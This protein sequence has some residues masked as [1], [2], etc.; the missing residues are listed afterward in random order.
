MIMKYEKTKQRHQKLKVVVLT[1]YGNGKLACMR[2]GFG[3]VHA[4]SIDHISGG[5]NNE[6][7]K[8]RGSGQLY[9]FLKGNNFPRGYQTLCMNCQFIK[10]F[11]N[12]EDYWHEK[13]AKEKAEGLLVEARKPLYLSKVTPANIWKYI[14]KLTVIQFE[15]DQIKKAF[16]VEDNDKEEQRI[17]SFLSRSVQS[18]KLQHVAHGVYERV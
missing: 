5:G 1:H 10:R 8:M 15:V 13:R 2:C 4:L 9:K 3:D 11:E 17:Y 16:N 14:N 12:K 18:A 7:R 6:R